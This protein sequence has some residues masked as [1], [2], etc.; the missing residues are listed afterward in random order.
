MQTRKI[1]KRKK[2]KPSGVDDDEITDTGAVAR[3]HCPSSD[4]INKCN[5]RVDNILILATTVIIILLTNKQT[6]VCASSKFS[7]LKWLCND[8]FKKRPVEPV[9]TE[10]SVVVEKV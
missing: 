1:K 4:T 8:R 6:R 3:S 5:I 9:I 10:E 2:L 7:W